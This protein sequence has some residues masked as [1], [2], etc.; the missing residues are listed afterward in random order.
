MIDFVFV[1]SGSVRIRT[2]RFFDDLAEVDNLGF[3]SSSEESSASEDLSLKTT[4]GSDFRFNGAPNDVVLV[5]DA[6]GMSPSDASP[7]SPPNREKA[8]FLGLSSA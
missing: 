5:C 3:T 1:P 7:S 4:A 8:L 6:S 2:K